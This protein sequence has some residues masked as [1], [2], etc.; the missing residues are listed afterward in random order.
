MCAA[1]P[2]GSSPRARRCWLAPL[3]L[4]PIS[5]SLVR[6]D[7]PPAGWCGPDALAGVAGRRARAGGEPSAVRVGHLGLCAYRP[8]GARGPDHRLRRGGLA[9]A[10][11]TRHTRA[12]SYGHRS[13]GPGLRARGH[14]H[15]TRAF[16][17]PLADQLAVS[18]LSTLADHRRQLGVEPDTETVL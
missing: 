9:L 4:A 7:A 15:C 1:G 13:Y 12:R 2:Y 17:T 10:R 18:G 5:P 8:L 11:P 16:C 6:L 3:S 14:G